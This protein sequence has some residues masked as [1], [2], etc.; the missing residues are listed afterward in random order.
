MIVSPILLRRPGRL[1]RR[2]YVPQDSTGSKTARWAALVL[3]AVVASLLITASL[4]CT[5]VLYRDPSGRELHVRS[6][7]KTTD[8]QGCKVKTPEGGELE[9]TGYK[10]DASQ[11][12]DLAKTVV[13]GAA[14]LP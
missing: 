7:F 8:I 9:L 5:D 10:S 4:G 1:A 3:F 12:I 13:N 14:K 11:A 6:Y 2:G